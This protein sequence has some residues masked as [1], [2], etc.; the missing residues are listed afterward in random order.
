MGNVWGSSQNATQ[1]PPGIDTRPMSELHLTEAE[2]AGYKSHSLS[3]TMYKTVARTKDPKLRVV[4]FNDDTKAVFRASNPAGHDYVEVPWSQMDSVKWI[5]QRIEDKIR[6]S[7]HHWRLATADGVIFKT[8]GEVVASSAAF[9]IK[10]Q[11]VLTLLMPTDFPDFVAS[12]LKQHNW[13]RTTPEPATSKSA[14]AK[15]IAEFHLIAPDTSAAWGPYL[16]QRRA[17]DEHVEADLAGYQGEDRPAIYEKIEAA[18]DEVLACTNLDED[19]EAAVHDC[20]VPLLADLSDDGWGNVSNAEVLS[21]IYSPTKPAA[22]D[23]YLEYHYRTRYSSVEFHCNMYYRTHA[24]ITDAKLDLTQPRGSGK[25]NGFR[26]FFEMGLADV[27]PRRRW[28]AIDERDFGVLEPQA[29]A[30][31]RILFGEPAGAESLAEQVSVRETLRLLLAS[32]GI[33]F[34]AAEND[35]D[36]VNL[37]GF[38]MADLRWEGLDGSERWLGRNLRRV[39]GC[40]PLK[41]DGVDSPDEEDDDEENDD[42][43]DED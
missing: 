2:Y 9:Q 21:R 22:V 8:F 32:V 3:D 16:A 27:P 37:D 15:C 1:F 36:S 7:M 11:V 30:L 17:A 5:A 40:A 13:K 24:A 41:E 31:H 19:A 39:A 34:Y 26:T 10:E 42:C 18:L 20:I 23:V 28:R 12:H 6:V 4:G 29:R 14:L 43:T 35:E 33:G 38:L 25:M